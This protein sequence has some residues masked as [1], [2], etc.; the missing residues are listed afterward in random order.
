MFMAWTRVLQSLL[1]SLA[2]AEARELELDADVE[3]APADEL[4]IA[5]ARMPEHCKRDVAACF[6]KLGESP[7]S[8]RGSLAAIARNACAKPAD[9]RRINWVASRT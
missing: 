8:S 4:E 5:S 2:R 6:N 1:V 3:T 7:W 9:R